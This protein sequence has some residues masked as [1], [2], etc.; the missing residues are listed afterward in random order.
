[1]KVTKCD[2]LLRGGAAGISLA[3]LLT[4]TAC[5]MGAASP[6]G[7]TAVP[8][9]GP[10]EIARP[11]A[12]V[13]GDLA[14]GEMPY[15][16]YDPAA[17]APLLKP[18]ERASLFGGAQETFDSACEAAEKE[19]RYMA[20]LSVQMEIAR[21]ASPN[22]AEV[23]EESAYIDGVYRDAYNDFLFALG[24]V[25]SS[26]HSGLLESRYTEEERALFLTFVGSGEEEPS[27]DLY[28]REDALELRYEELISADEVDYDAVC[29]LYVELV[30]LRREIAAE[31]GYD[32]YA[33]YA[34]ETQYARQYTPEEA[35]TFC[36]AVRDTFAPLAQRSREQVYGR[37]AEL[38]D[39]DRIDCSPAAIL[40][41]LGTGAAHFPTEVSEAY[42]YMMTYG[43][44][45]IDP[46]EVSLQTGYTALLY[47]YNE[48]FIYNAPIGHYTDYSTLFHEFGH[49]FNYYCVGSDLLFRIADGDLSELQSQGMEVM[50]FPY[51]KD[52]FGDDAAPLIRADVLMGLI[53]AVVDGAMYDEFQQ[54]VFAEP[55]LTP[56][57][58]QDIYR[59]VY[60][61]YGYEPYDG[62]EEEWMD[63][64][65]N[66][67]LPFY[68]I[69]YATSA[70]SALELCLV[71]QSDPAAA[72]EAYMTVVKT[73]GEQ[74]GFAETLDAAGLRSPLSACR[75]I[76]REVA[77]SGLL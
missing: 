71:E 50:F 18:I 35:G 26:S 30:E 59:Q 77:D 42:Q 11:A 17:F 43:L 36:Q 19:L 20:T 65:H 58:V 73:D 16:H 31:E 70:V 63:Q 48:P 5:G 76:A 32:S 38:Y 44:Y 46:G 29:G 39:S 74:E 56:E 3:L 15:E 14:Y 25:A 67:Q 53:D 72:M 9:D 22:D 33:A 62:F 40:S 51:Y 66:F 7:D 68:Y 49:F 54:K 23:T 60:T 10:A 28:D 64:I 69:S 47:A 1:M 52:F 2:C 12:L 13:R 34:Y 27:D 57:R 4:L 8:A 6:A 75:E 37:S 41:A 45:N 24:R 21:S 55:D 61:G